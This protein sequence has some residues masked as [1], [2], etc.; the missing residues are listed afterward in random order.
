M[1]F[2]GRLSKLIL[3]VIVLTLGLSTHTVAD[4]S[5]DKKDKK[6]AL[7]GKP[8]LWQEPADI[9]SFNLLLGPGG[10]AMKPDLSK[11]SFIS[12]EKGGYSKKYRVRDGSGRI[13]VVKI[14]KEAQSE[15]AAARLLWAAGYNTDITYLVPSVTIEG[16]GTLENAR[17]E[18]RPPEMKRMGEWKWDQNSFVGTN[19]LQGLKVM[20]VL[21]GNWDIKDSNNRILVVPNEVTGAVEQR[22]IVSD[23]GGTL[24]KTGIIWLTRS[25]NKPV[26]FAKAKFIDGVKGNRVDFHYSGKRKGVVRDI[27]VDQARWLGQLLSR[28]SDEQIR[29]AF[30]AANYNAEEVSMLAGAVRSR[31]NEL[32]ALPQA[33]SASR[34]TIR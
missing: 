19:E 23:L 24:G 10:E 17:F 18:A 7:E 26:D 6:A 25:R 30:R 13:W 34:I 2:Q 29:D 27:T 5:K 11:V 16:I 1:L 28:L 4:K 12:E 20:M 14:G 22:Y 9:A 8:V 33:Q 31:I 21:I 3:A 15:T 32:V